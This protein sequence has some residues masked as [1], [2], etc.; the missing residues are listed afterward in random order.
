MHAQSHIYLLSILD[1]KDNNN[2]GF[3]SV[4]DDYSWVGYIIV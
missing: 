3:P 2:V 1:A 4:R